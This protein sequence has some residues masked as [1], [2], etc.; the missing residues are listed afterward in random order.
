VRGGSLAHNIMVK[1]NF[2]HDDWGISDVGCRR[3]LNE[4]K[5]LM[6]PESGVWLVA[7]GMGGHEAGDIASGI[8]VKHVETIGQAVSAADLS[9]RFTDRLS[10]ANAEIQRISGERGGAIIGATV[11]ALLAYEQ[12]YACVW[13]GDSRLYRIRNGIIEQVSKDHTEVQELIDDG[14]ISLEEAENWPRKN[15]ITAA[16]G[17]SADISIDVVHGEINRADSYLLC[18]DGLT[19][20]IDDSEIL[21]I[22]YGRKPQSACEQLIELTLQRGAIDNVTVIIIQ[23]QDMDATVPIGDS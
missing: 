16:V 11:V 13:S 7:D 21:E 10:Q 23:F 17:V 6:S 14:T 15:V 8:I 22:V 18:S 3:E 1:I 9:A 5:L 4:D 19:E 2:R 20:H 12:H